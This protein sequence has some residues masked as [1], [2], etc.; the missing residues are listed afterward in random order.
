[1]MLYG[2]CV[3]KWFRIVPIEADVVA[4]GV[5]AVQR[6]I[7]L[8]GRKARAIVLRSAGAVSA[9]EVSSFQRK[10]RKRSQYETPA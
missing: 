10:K 4:E 1:M 7:F 2:L 6:C 8:K 9:F 5:D 3:K